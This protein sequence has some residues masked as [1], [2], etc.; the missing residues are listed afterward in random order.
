MNLVSRTITGSVLVV[1]GVVL[2]AL[3]IFLW[4]I[5]VTWIYGIP[6]VVIGVFILLNEKEDEIEEIK[7]YK[8]KKRGK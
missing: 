3:G 8:G 4:P 1:L 2:F 5:V 6:L 7:S